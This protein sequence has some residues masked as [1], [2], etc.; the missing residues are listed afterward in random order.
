LFTAFSQQQKHN[1]CIQLVSDHSQLAY[2]NTVTQSLR[3]V[4]HTKQQCL[5]SA[6]S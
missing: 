6:C 2:C 5:H 3:I 4:L 1:T